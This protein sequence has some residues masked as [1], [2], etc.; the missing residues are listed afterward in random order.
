MAWRSRRAPVAAG[1]PVPAPSAQPVD[2]VPVDT[3]PVGIVPERPVV[4]RT[5]LPVGTA[6]VGDA[7][8]KLYYPIG[9]AAQHA[10]PAEF[11]VFFQSSGGAERDGFKP[12]GDC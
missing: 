3:V 9:C 4:G 5:R 12:S 11:Q 10:I 8:L 1:D 6:Y 2:P 7:R